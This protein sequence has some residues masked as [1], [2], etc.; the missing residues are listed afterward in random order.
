[1]SHKGNAL[2]PDRLSAPTT[3]IVYMHD[4]EISAPDAIQQHRSPHLFNAWLQ[5]IRSYMSWI[6]AASVVWEIICLPLNPIW[7]TANADQ[8]AL[9]TIRMINADLIIA[10]GTLFATLVV[11]GS[12]RWPDDGYLQI[13]L[14]TIACA[15]GF[16][17][18]NYWVFAEAPEKA[19]GHAAAWPDKTLYAAIAAHLKWVVLPAVAFWQAR[20]ATH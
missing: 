11:F 15:W 7:G 17:M 18:I 12:N 2:Q 3:H 8:I 13:G 6:F 19:L 4:K 9:S 1:M 10:L 20:R 16:S 5:T 14:M